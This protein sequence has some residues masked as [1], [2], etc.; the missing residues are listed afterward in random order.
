ME[1]RGMTAAPVVCGGPTRLYLSGEQA[2]LVA[3]GFAA[4]PLEAVVVPGGPGAASA[5]KTC[6]AAWTKGSA[7]LLLAIRCLA[8][9]EGVDGALVE[10]WRGT[11]PELP[12]RSEQA[13]RENALKAWR[14]TGE[15]DEQAVAFAAADLPDGF[16]RAAAEIYRRLHGFRGADPVPSL[17]QVLAALGGGASPPV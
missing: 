3:G 13:A 15:M 4:G 11:W 6:Y 12:A 16:A 1:T 8:Q 9:A 17:D 7:A 5:L 14:F 10:E 2:S